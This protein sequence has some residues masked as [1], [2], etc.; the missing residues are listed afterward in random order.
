[1]HSIANHTNVSLCWHQ[2]VQHF[3]YSVMI[4]M[5]RFVV[6]TYFLGIVSSYC[7]KHRCCQLSLSRNA[8]NRAWQ[9]FMPIPLCSINDRWSQQYIRPWSQH[10]SSSPCAVS[11]RHRKGHARSRTVRARF[12][13]IFKFTLVI[14]VWMLCMSAIMF[15]HIYQWSAL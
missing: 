2:L 4:V 3:L 6:T 10:S 15:E 14:I 12:L 1:M 7:R 13:G 8:C 5:N 11:M 9:S